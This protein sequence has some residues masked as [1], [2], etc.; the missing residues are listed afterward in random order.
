MFDIKKPIKI[1]I[2]IL[3]LLIG[4][5]LCQKY[6]NKWHLVVYLLKKPLLAKQNYNI[7]NKRY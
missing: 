5:Y 1:K 4:V 3:N 2:N 7:Y 6:K